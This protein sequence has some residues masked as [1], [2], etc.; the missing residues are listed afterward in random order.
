[1]SSGYLIGE[2]LLSRI[3]TTID[4]VD[5]QPDRIGSASIPT[6]LQSVGGGGTAIRQCKTIADWEAGTP[7]YVEVW[8][9]GI[10]GKNTPTQ[11]IEAWNNLYRV[12]TGSFVYIAKAGNGIW[13]MIGSGRPAGE[14]AVGSGV[15]RSVTAGSEDLSILP[16]YSPGKQQI[17]S[18]VN[19]CLQWV[20]VASCF[21]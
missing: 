4:R 12:K 3:R 6:R 20:D 11:P 19:G 9:T 8:E 15:C 13:Y 18:H 7:Q 2:S 16:G 5:A 10:A 1:M 17:L 21:T 14:T